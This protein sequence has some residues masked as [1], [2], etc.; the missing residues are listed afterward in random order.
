MYRIY[1]SIL[2]QQCILYREHT[3]LSIHLSF[4]PV[5]LDVQFYETVI[6]HQVIHILHFTFPGQVETYTATRGIFLMFLCYL[7]IYLSVYLSIYLPI[8][9]LFVQILLNS[10]FYPQP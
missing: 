6:Q 8:Y 10:K 7:S 2:T 3:Y 4:L 1:Y 5:I 9:L